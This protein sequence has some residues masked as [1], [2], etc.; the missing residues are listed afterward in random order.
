MSAS[1]GKLQKH[2]GSESA[3][4]V[5]DAERPLRGVFVHRMG[6]SA[7]DEKE[8]AALWRVHGLEPDALEGPAQRFSRLPDFRLMRDGVP[9]AYCEVKTLWRH[10]WTVNIL[11]EDRPVEERRDTSSKPV[12]ERIIGDLIT[13]SRQLQAGNSSHKLLNFVVLVNRDPEASP[14]L[15]TQVLVRPIIRSGRSL[16]A[17]RA[18]KLVEEVQAFRRCVDLCLWVTP[19][20]DGKLAIDA[21]ILFNPSLRSFAEE[22][23]GLRGGKLISLEPAA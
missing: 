18:A 3:S 4:S 17:R 20:A 15:L 12:D 16:K 13:A 21:C 23:A 10:C 14:A 6:E 1:L 7:G 8:V 5:S 2:S 11:H 19:A 9:W 22:I